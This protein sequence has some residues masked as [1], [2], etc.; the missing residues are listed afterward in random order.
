MELALSSDEYRKFDQEM[1]EL[2]YS[3]FSRWEIIIFPNVKTKAVANSVCKFIINNLIKIES[4]KESAYLT[5]TIPITHLIRKQIHAGMWLLARKPFFI[6]VIYR[7]IAGYLITGGVIKI[8]YST[9]L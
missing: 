6:G 9:E 7:E 3:C 5:L 4:E 2:V 1:K 8:Y